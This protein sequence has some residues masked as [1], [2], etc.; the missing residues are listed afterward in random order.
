[1]QVA[2]RAFEMHE[3]LTVTAIADRATVLHNWSTHE[4]RQ[5][6]FAI[7]LLKF[8]ACRAVHP[9]AYLSQRFLHI[10]KSKFGITLMK[11]AFRPHSFINDA[12]TR[13]YGIQDRERPTGFSVRSLS[14]PTKI[15][16]CSRT[17]SPDATLFPTLPAGDLPTITQYF[18][19]PW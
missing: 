2:Y 17:A 11:V 12:R 14:A 7:E 4:K 9:D 19:N 16:L 13:L 18:L 1:V 6:D 8:S 10:D 15:A 3:R 5:H